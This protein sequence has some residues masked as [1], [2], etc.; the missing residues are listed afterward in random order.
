MSGF[1]LAYANDFTGSTLP[2]GWTAFSGA[3]S[4]DAGSTWA[5]GQVTV[6]GGVL[7]LTT[8]QVG[9]DDNDWVSGGVSDGSVPLTYGAFFVRS[10][11][12]GVGPTQV[13]LLWPTTAWPPE[14]DFDETY[15]GDTSTQATLHYTSANLEIHDNLTIDMT[16]WHTWGIVW[17]PDSIIYTVDGNE[18][19]SIT[20]PA[21]IPDQPMILN[22]QQQ[23]WCSSGFACP[24]AS[25]STD[26][27]WVALYSPTSS[28]SPPTTTT[29][30]PPTTTTTVGSPPPTSSSPPTTQS[31]SNKP[32]TT[33]T[34]MPAGRRPTTDSVIL[35]SF[36]TN[37]WA[38]SPGL[39]VRT[40]R[41]A[42]LIVREDDTEV[43]LTGYSSDEP[44]RGAALAIARA[45][46]VS[47]G[48]LLHVQLDRL[49]DSTVK[50]V[51]RGVIS[52]GASVT[53]SVRSRSVVALLR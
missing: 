52:G 3:A 31:S 1:A 9:S 42:A 11:M 8:S 14:I 27:D 24:T 22:I 44:S 25:A 6:S 38:L 32:P 37:S 30:A 43:I 19:A 4:G 29:T 47:V 41:V 23:T 13:E 28:S 21:D 5:P 33:T 53:A 20:T 12:T 34:T 40:A 36:A 45:R 16:Q 39:R 18:W 17:T 50:I 7:Q 49:H 46:A 26:V 51:I 15:G 35:T 48:A 10:K 2:S